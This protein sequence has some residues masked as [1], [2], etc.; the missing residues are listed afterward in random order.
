MQPDTTRGK[1]LAFQRS[2]P[3]PPWSRISAEEFQTGVE[4]ESITEHI[5][6]PQTFY[7]A[8]M[9]T[10]R[11]RLVT[12]TL[13]EPEGFSDQRE[14]GGT[15][16]SASALGRRCEDVLPNRL[17]GRER[18]CLSRHPDSFGLIPCLFVD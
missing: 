18:R 14:L 7:L 4:I 17:R 12:G 15:H 13:R 2:H 9:R 16:R 5:G 10:F 6:F 11:P 1:Y 8:A 3:A